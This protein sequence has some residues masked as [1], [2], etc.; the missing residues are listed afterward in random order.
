MVCVKEQKEAR[1]GGPLLVRHSI[2]LVPSL[3][4]IRQ[5]TA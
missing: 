3:I 2:E 5:K 1:L 4:L